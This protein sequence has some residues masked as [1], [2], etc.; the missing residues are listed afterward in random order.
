MVRLRDLAG[1][2]RGLLPIPTK[3]SQEMELMV[4]LLPSF[5]HFN[6]FAND[7]RLAG[8]RLNSAMLSVFD[9]EK[10]LSLIPKDV[11]VPLY[12]DIK[13]R[14]LRVTKVHANSEF[15]EFSLNHP[16][17][18]ESLPV[19]ILFK[20]GEDSALLVCLGNGEDATPAD[21]CGPGRAHGPG[22][23]EVPRPDR[24]YHRL[25]VWQGPQFKVRA[26]ESIYI[27]DKS[28]RVGGDQFLP[29]EL[30]KIESVKK[31]GIDRWFL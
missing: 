28:L 29:A 15:L 31:F 26:G 4:T 12:F 10:E 21:L 1:M 19:P 6:K 13:G 11:R 24:W 2:G 3:V 5:D 27:R 23:T 20:G 30:E 8:I 18:L 14:Q 9:L 7:G 16:I 17:N 25:A 22:G